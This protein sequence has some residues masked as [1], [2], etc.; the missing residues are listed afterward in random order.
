[1]LWTSVDVNLVSVL[2]ELIVAL[3]GLVVLTA[4]FLSRRDIGHVLGYTALGG[5]VLSFISVLALWGMD[6][7]G[8][9]RM[10]VLDEYALF[11]HAVLLIAAGITILISLDY[12]RQEGLERFEFYTLL[13]FATVGMMLMAASQE[14][15]MIFLGLETMSISIYALAGWRK[16]HPKGHEAALKYLLLGA[17]SGAF[18]L[19]GIALIYGATGTTHLKDIADILASGKQAAAQSPMLFVGVALLLVG[20]GFKVASVPFHM[21]TP[22]VYDGAPA[23]IT[24]YMAAGVKAAAFAAFLR[25]FFYSLVS[26]HADWSVILA[27]L[28]VATMTLGNLVALA[29]ENIKRMLAYSSIAHAGYILVGMVAGGGQIANASILY[30]LLAYTLMNLGAFGVVTIFGRKGELNIMIENYRGMGFRYPVLGAVMAIFMF[31]LAG[32]PPTAG[33]FAKF[34]VFSAAVSEGYTWLVV[35]AVLNSLVSVY[36]YFR[37]T[38]KI[39]MQA[40]EKDLEGVAMGPAMFIALGLMALGTIWVGVFPNTYLDLAKEALPRLF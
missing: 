19:Y 7:S 29:Q 13:L 8:F 31:S 12:M 33:F 37:V 25:V 3:S 39:Y 38:M 6:T 21:W 11:F 10:I 23:P 17:F 2:P 15:I 9:K 30:Y 26:L 18:F 28:A 20:F 5:V 24:A 35:I 14:L 1:M 16:D 34:Y 36:Y 32:I 22:D 27:V 40:P 4:G